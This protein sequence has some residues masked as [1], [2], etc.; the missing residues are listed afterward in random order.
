MQQLPLAALD[1]LP[2]RFKLV[3]MIHIENVNCNATNR[4]FGLNNFITHLKMIIP[5]L[6]A[7]MKEWRQL[8]C[9]AIIRRD[10]F[11]LVHITFETCLR[12]IID[13]G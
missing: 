12:E 8:S 13:L 2:S 3:G 7:W 10:I 6:L 1:Q 11:A 5:L 9:R 4:I